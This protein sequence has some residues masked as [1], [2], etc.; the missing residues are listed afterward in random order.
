M[1]LIFE[2]KDGNNITFPTNCYF[3]IRV[4]VFR[5][6]TKFL[7]V[8]LDDL[9]DIVKMMAYAHLKKADVEP[10]EDPQED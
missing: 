4:N 2:D 6:R 1:T 7:D 9:R 8:M 5:Y 10:E 3:Y